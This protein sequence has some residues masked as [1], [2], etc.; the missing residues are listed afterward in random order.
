MVQVIRRKKPSKKQVVIVEKKKQP[1][2]T[3]KHQKPVSKNQE[4]SKEDIEVPGNME[5]TLKISELPEAVTIGC[6]TK[7]LHFISF[8]DLSAFFSPERA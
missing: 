3:T 5:V 2:I 8:N 7:K 1:I 4:I 6:N